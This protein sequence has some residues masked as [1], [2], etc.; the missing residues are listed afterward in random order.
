MWDS[1]RCCNEK[2]LTCLQLVCV[3]CLP[4]PSLQPF[5]FLW[6]HYNFVTCLHAV[7]LYS[8]LNPVCVL[9]LSLL[10][11]AKLMRQCLQS[12]CCLTATI[13][14]TPLAGTFESIYNQYSIYII[15]GFIIIYMFHVALLII[16]NGSAPCTTCLE[17]I[18][19]NCHLHQHHKS[20]PQKLTIHNFFPTSRHWIAV[21]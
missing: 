11:L 18:V 17:Q 13:V 21:N 6:N 10:L 8:F 9:Q 12:C 14:A 7:C 20:T 16:A 1:A 19:W 15:F 2:I 3:L 5:R 4:L